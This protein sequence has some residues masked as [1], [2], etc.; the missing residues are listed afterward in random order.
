MHSNIHYGVSGA[1]HLRGGGG[2]ACGSG[3]T[4]AIKESQKALPNFLSKYVFG[5]QSDDHMLSI[6]W[7]NTRGADRRWCVAAIKAT[8]SLK[9]TE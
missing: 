6:N 8:K 1:S 5:E 2:G 4:M 9:Q 3:F 7:A